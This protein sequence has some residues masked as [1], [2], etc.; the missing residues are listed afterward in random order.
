MDNHGSEQY[1]LQLTETFQ[2]FYYSSEPVLVR[3]ETTAYPLEKGTEIATSCGFLAISELL[4]A[5]GRAVGARIDYYDDD[6]EAQSAEVTP[7]HR[8]HIRF[9]EG[10]GDVYRISD[11]TFQIVA[12]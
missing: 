1:E 3:N 9:I 12:K 7:D 5:D 2:R 4:M 10:S 6:G 11:C 8:A